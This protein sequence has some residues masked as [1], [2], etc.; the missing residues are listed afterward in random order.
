MSPLVQISAGVEEHAWSSPR[1]SFAAGRKV[2]GGECGPIDGRKR[3]RLQLRNIIQGR[4]ESRGPQ[5]M[6]NNSGKKK[7]SIPNTHENTVFQSG[8]SS[9]KHS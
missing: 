8:I 2:K 9:L 5:G 6:C 4:L 3:G 1:D 7:I